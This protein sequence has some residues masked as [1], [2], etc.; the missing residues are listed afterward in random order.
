MQAGARLRKRAE[1]QRVYAE[2]VKVAGRHIVVFALVH[3]NEENRLGITATRR[4]GPA[5]VR[6]RARRR[7]RELFRHATCLP[8][9]Y[10]VDIVVNVRSSCAVAPWNEL[11]GDF[12]ECLRKISRRLGRREC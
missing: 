9:A 11:E 7:V 5:V 3:E 12:A 10:R 4:V 1:F 8:D 2:G 6:N